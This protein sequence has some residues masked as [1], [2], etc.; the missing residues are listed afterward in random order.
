MDDGRLYFDN[1]AT[2]FPKPLQVYEAMDLYAR[3]VGGTAGRSAHD[4]SL[5]GAR[6]LFELRQTLAELAGGDED[7]VVL[8]KNATEALN[9][10]L[11]S[12]AR[13]GV[14]V[15]HGPLEHNAV[16]RPLNHLA[17]QRGLTLVEAPGDAHGRIAPDSLA[18]FLA[19]T[20]ADLL[21]TLHASNVHGLA[22]DL[23]AIGE[24]CARHD[25]T[26]VVDAAQ[27]GGALPLDMPAMHI[28][29]LCLTG[30]KS[31]LGPTGTGALLLSARC[32]DRI[33][34]LLHG[35]TGSA[36]NQ[37]VMPDFLPDRLEAG[38]PNTLGA[39]GLLAG[40]Q[41]LQALSVEAVAR[42]EADL[43]ALMIERLHGLND[44]TLFGD[45]DGP[46]VA[47][48]SFTSCLAPS[49][50][51]YLLSEKYGIAV[52]PGLHCAPRAHRTLGTLPAGTVR[53]AP[54]PLT[55]LTAVDE[56]TDA[57]A[58]ILRTAR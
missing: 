5:A 47:T 48:V 31:L 52:R 34:P 7:L 43:R 11:F 3:T 33:E 16:M 37:E 56:V 26:L 17:R 8:T 15:A 41:Y 49:D 10:A 25:T 46:A 29:A 4:R 35:G 2:S 54:G 51:A 23:A 55:P 24:I 58:D 12:L 39:A 6:L 19:Q 40:V 57:V 30:H 38:T 28:D 1:A 13:P 9:I 44:V 20:K 32:A 22:Q 53:L 36:S 50:M 14:I 27:S 45:A 18:A 42:H 21:V